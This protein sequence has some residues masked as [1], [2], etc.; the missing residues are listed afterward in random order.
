MRKD[1][2]GGFHDS[3]FTSFGR[4]MFPW[5]RVNVNENMIRNLSLLLKIVQNP[6]LNNNYPQESLAKVVLGKRV[7][8]DYLL[9]V[10]RPP[11]APGL[12]LL[13]KLKPGYVRSLSNLLR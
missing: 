5:F 8:L 3:G 1:L 10:A 13:R 4:V 9:A 11:T 7:A 12:T 2:A 6:L